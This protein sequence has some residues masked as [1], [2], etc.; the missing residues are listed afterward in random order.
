MEYDFAACMCFHCVGRLAA[1][2]NLS[3]DANDTVIFLNWSAPLK[4][5]HGIS[6]EHPDISS[7]N[8]YIHNIATNQSGMWNV[9]NSSLIFSGLP[10]EDDPNPCHK[11]SFTVSANNVVGEGER[12]EEVFQHFEGG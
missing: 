11:Y 7:Y 2:G 6:N 3:V 8:V 4:F 5:T 12:S 9:N 10:G 1:L